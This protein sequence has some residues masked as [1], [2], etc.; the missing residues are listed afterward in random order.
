MPNIFLSPSLQ[1]GNNY[2]SGGTEAQYMNY[3]AD[4]LE[5]YL[6]ANSI[7]Y[8]RSRLPNTL[9]NAISQSNS[10]DYDLHLA[11]HSNASP[12][13]KKGQFRGIQAYYYPTSTSGRRAA[14]ALVEALKAI[15]P[16]PELVY[17]VPTTTITEVRR[18]KAPA[19]LMEIGYHDN[20]EDEAFIKNNLQLIASSLAKGLTAY[21]GLAFR[22]VCT[23]NAGKI[24]SSTRAGEYVLACTENGTPLNIRS[25]PSLTGEKIG[26]IPNKQK[27]LLIKDYSS[28]FA[29]IRYNAVEGYAVGEYLC[30]CGNTQMTQEG[31]VTTDGSR[32]NLRAKPSLSSNIIGRIPDKATVTVLETVGNWYKVIYM[33]VTGYVLS[34]FVAL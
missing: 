12:E 19:V 22:E 33:N 14:N 15:Y 7:G 13:D 29:N 20:R 31:M 3:L 26:Q 32:L 23:E 30:R 10:A 11:L 2:V 6:T 24:V 28:G 5:P 16:E 21:F 17:T 9:A 25:T 34:D 27:A 1:T 18:T 8:T 4:A